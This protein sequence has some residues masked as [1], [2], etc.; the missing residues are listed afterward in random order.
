[1]TDLTVDSTARAQAAA[2]RAGEISARELLDLHLARIAE[3]NPELNAIVSL[4]EERARDGRGRRRPGAR[5]GRGRGPAAR[6][7]LRGEGHPRAAGVAD[8]VRLADLRRRTWPT[9]TTCSSSGSARPARCSSARPTC[10]SS[11]PGRTP[12]TPSSASPATRSTRRRSAGGSSGGAACAL[13][14]GM[15][16]L[17][18]GSDMGGSLRNPASFCGVVGHAAVARPGARVAALQPVGEHVR[19]WPDGPQRRRPRPAAVRARRPRPPGAAGAGRPGHVVRARRSS[20]RR[21]PGC[22]WRARWTSAVRSWSTTRSRTSY[23]PPRRGCPTPERA[24]SE[25]HP[26]LSL[27]DDTF[28]TLRAWHFQA[29]LGALLAE[30]PDLV[31]ALAGGQH[32]GRRVAD[33]RRRGAGLHPAH[34]ALGDACGSSS[35]TTTCCCC[36]PRRCRRSRSSRS[37]RRRSTARQMPDYLAWMR[38]AYFITVTGCPAISV[39]AGTHRRRAARRGPAGRQARL[40]PAA[41]RGRRGRRGPARPLTPPSIV[42]VKKLVRGPSAPAFCCGLSTAVPRTP[43][44]EGVHRGVENA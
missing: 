2:V 24:V 8:D 28:R 34:R 39:P 13:A 19:R 29:K 16:P 14:S 10:R 32:P 25:A 21:S 30:H 18:D 20:R 3:R 15:V 22:G 31:Q 37:S 9:T 43:V 5:V 11:R 42:R 44:H 6:P 7:A 1:M 17:A 12:S 40:R 26:D 33:R 41:A 36:R 23:A 35:A 4:D 27:A 38:S